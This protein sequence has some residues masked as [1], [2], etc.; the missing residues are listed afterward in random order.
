M[1]THEQFDRLEAINLAGLITAGVGSA[2]FV[3]S[4]TII[5]VQR[6]KA[7]KEAEQQVARQPGAELRL[8]AA[9]LEVRF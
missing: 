3:T 5:L 4:W 1:V 9:G 2:L 8:D 6:S 7:R